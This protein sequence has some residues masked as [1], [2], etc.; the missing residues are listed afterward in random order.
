M[1][2]V[3]GLPFNNAKAQLEAAPYNFK[4]VRKNVDNTAA[5]D[6]VINTT[7]FVGTDVQ[8]GAEVTLFVSRGQVS[9]PNL[10]GMDIEEAKA[11]LDELGLKYRTTGDP[12]STSPENQ[13]TVQSVGP[14]TQV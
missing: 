1:P 11:A 7:P 12:N 10:V 4:V 14:G 6:E 9:V 5:K 13:V 2:D 8:V 3:R